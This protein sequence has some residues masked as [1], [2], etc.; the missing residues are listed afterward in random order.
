MEN[1]LKAETEALGTEKNLSA[2]WLE[3]AAA[4][5]EARGYPATA[6]LYRHEAIR[7]QERGR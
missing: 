4:R 5:W 6:Q 1:I 2:K 3:E 7:V